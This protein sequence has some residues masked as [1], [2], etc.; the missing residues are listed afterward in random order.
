MSHRALWRASCVAVLTCGA[1]SA[2]ADVI[3][4]NVSITGTLSAGATANT[5]L[6]DIDFSFPA[7]VVGDLTHPVRSGGIEISYEA[8][9]TVGLAQDGM[10]LSVLGALDGT[11]LIEFQETVE[12]F[13]DPGNPV[14]IGVYNVTLDM[15]DLLPHVATIDFDYAASHIRVHK[16]IRLLAEDDPSYDN[17]FSNVSLIE[18][19]LREVPEP[20]TAALMALAGLSMAARR[21]SA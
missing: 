12:D 19:N 3:F 17:D 6:T 7:A 1:A 16:T 13:A 14:V 2:S 15:N 10:V 4:S 9:S 18:Q 8:T 5:G 20:A 21:R 11:G